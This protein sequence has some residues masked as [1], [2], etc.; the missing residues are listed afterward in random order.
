MALWQNLKSGT[1]TP[2]AVHF[3]LRTA[4][5]GCVLLCFRMNLTVVF[6]ISL[7]NGMSVFLGVS[8]NLWIAFGKMVI[9]PILILL[10][11]A[12]AVSPFC[13]DLLNLFHWC[14]KLFTVEVF[15]FL[16]F[17]LLQGMVRFLGMT[18]LPWFLSQ[19]NQYVLACIYKQ[20]TDFCMRMW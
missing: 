5:P 19:C 16:G 7:K 9:V 20:T 3:L 2:P 11:Q 1:V 18:P 15:H 14:F 17:V 4:L 13:S 8:L 12:W 10:P 6:I